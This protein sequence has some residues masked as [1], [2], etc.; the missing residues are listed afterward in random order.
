MSAL[1]KEAATCAG[2]VESLNAIEL[3]RVWAKLN[4]TYDNEYQQ[5]FAHIAKIINIAPIS[6]PSAECLRSMIYTVDQHLRMLQRFDIATEEWSPLVCVL[7][8]TKLDAETRNKWET[9]DVMPNKPCLNT[10]TDFLEKQ[11]HGIRN[12]QLSTKL[13]VQIMPTNG[14]GGG[15]ASKPNGQPKQRYHPYETTKG[16]AG[17]NQNTSNPKIPGPECPQCGK[18]VNHFLWHCETFRAL[19]SSE[20]IERL[21]KWGICEVCLVAKHKAVDCTKGTC[22][23]C[24]T[25]KHNSMVCPQNV[26]K[27]VHH[28]RGGKRQQRGDKSE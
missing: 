1:E 9:R 27:R 20:K 12:A 24:K 21:G 6:S 17:S 4:K 5:V 11:I 13:P 26:G 3:E 15:K 18:N 19:T 28:A 7:M 16:A 22:P 25:A 10:L 8:L 14:N 2:R 23:I